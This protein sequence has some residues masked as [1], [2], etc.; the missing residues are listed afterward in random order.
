MAAY[1]IGLLHDVD[2]GPEIVEYLERIDGTLAPHGGRFVV[3]GGEQTLLEG[4]SSAVVV[5]IEFPDRAAADAWY[6][7]DAYQAILPLRTEHSRSVVWI[8]DGV[9]SGHRATDVL[10]GTHVEVA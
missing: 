7:S 5:V 8:L 2:L 1:G 4:D 6:R 9:E 3:H 10:D